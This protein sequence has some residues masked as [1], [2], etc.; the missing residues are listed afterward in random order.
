MASELAGRAATLEKELAELESA[1]NN[2]AALKKSQAEA[3]ESYRKLATQL[4]AGRRP[5]PA[6]CRKTSPRACRLSAWRAAHFLIDVTQPTRRTGAERIRFGRVPRQRRIRASHLRPL[7]KV[8]SGGE[9]A[10]LSLAV[11]VAVLRAGRSLHGVRRSGFRRRRRGRR[12]R[13]SRAAR[14]SASPGRRI[15]V[16]HLPQ[17]A[18]EG[19]HH[20]R[21]SKLTDGKTTRT[22]I[23]ELTMDE[24]VEEIARM[25]GG[26]EIT[27]KARE[28][29][30]RDV[31]DGGLARS[32]GAR[33]QAQSLTDSARTASRS[34]QARA[35]GLLDA[36]D[37]TGSPA[38]CSARTASSRD[39]PARTPAARQSLPGVLRSTHR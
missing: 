14:R 22:T 9:L 15:C 12:N 13:G 24:R 11:Q 34:A 26:T 38:C 29:A 37:A 5:A 8:A 31:A 16:T 23:S 32:E 17:V 27:S 4:S 10:R 28:H 36:F 3:L 7:A 19:H 25:L 39:R 30:A 18:K 35:S 6:R 21:V 2:L 33:R 1:D 20:L